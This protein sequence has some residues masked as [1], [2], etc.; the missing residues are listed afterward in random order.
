M[1]DKIKI[2]HNFKEIINKPY[3]KILKDLKNTTIIEIEGEVSEIIIISTM[4]HGNETCGFKAMI[5][6]LRKK[7]KPHFS[8]LFI[9][10]NIPAFFK[11]CRYTN[12]QKDMNRIWN[13]KGTSDQ[14]IQ[15]QKIKDYLSSKQVK[16]SLDIHSNAGKNPPYSIILDKKNLC[17]AKKISTI[18]LILN[19]ME[20]SFSGWIHK[21][22]ENS[23]SV[24]IECGQ[25]DDKKSIDFAYTTIFSLVMN[26]L[27]EKE[28][29]VIFE[30]VGI[31]KAK[32][33]KLV[34]NKDI[35]TFN[36]KLVPKNTFF[37]KG[38]SNGFEIEELN[39]DSVI[40][41]KK[42]NYYFK[43]DQYIAMASTDISRAQKY[44]FCYL[45]KKI[46]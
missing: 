42:N 36:F 27:E 7:I 38:E 33:S 1:T 20:S 6:F 46:K 17:L 10:G 29:H 30:K 16:Y 40:G 28:K 8:I 19:F 21:Q 34:F 25:H 39:T 32:H 43:Q 4:L 5:N 26:K 15:V 9:I 14:E 2:I 18:H 13:S 22:F 24:I 44:C 23:F 41:F 12:N 3:E 35:E 45:I 37:A 11:K 31:I